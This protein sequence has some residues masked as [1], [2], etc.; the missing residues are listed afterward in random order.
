[1]GV[2]VV[3]VVVIVD[4]GSVVVVVVDAI[5]ETIVTVVVDAVIEKAMHYRCCCCCCY[6]RRYAL[7]WVTRG[8][9][10]RAPFPGK[11]RRGPARVSG[12]SKSPM[13]EEEEWRWVAANDGVTMDGGSGQ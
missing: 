7:D 9:P 12:R 3:G 11:R 2:V 4:D 1:M 5:A 10:E 13:H 8:R 6:F